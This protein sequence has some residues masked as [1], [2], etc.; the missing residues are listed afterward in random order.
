M[1][2]VRSHAK[3][4]GTFVSGHYRKS[5]GGGEIDDVLDKVYGKKG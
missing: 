3:R 2:Y 5:G 1:P 4:D